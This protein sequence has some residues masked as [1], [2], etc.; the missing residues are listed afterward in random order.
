MLGI[1]VPQLHN[2]QITQ[3]P[4]LLD[5][6]GSVVLTGIR[7]ADLFLLVCAVR[8]AAQAQ[9]AHAA[10]AGHAAEGG[11]VSIVIESMTPQTAKP[12]STGPR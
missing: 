8:I 12:G 4:N 9:T 11:R 3:L 2:Y 6:H 5:S 10:Q 1:L 7:V